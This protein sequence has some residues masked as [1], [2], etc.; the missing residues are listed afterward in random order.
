MLKTIQKILLEKYGKLIP[1]LSM[2][3]AI[4][5]PPPI[6]SVAQPLSFF[7]LSSQESVTSILAP[8]EP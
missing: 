1:N 3:R 4:P 7:C 2:H 6:Q 5:I 8:E